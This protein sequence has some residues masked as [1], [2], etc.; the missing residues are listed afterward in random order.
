LS[1]SAESSSRT[2]FGEPT[3]TVPLSISSSSECRFCAPSCLRS[4]MV[5]F[6]EGSDV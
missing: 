1:R 6:I 2:V 4:R 5:F 3:T